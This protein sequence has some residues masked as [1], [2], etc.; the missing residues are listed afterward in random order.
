[1]YV[2]VNYDIFL[3][4]VGLQR[5]IVYICVVWRNATY[6]SIIIKIFNSNN[7]TD[8]GADKLY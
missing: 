4:T 6:S 8:L 3:E 1:M 7:L 2:M 5:L